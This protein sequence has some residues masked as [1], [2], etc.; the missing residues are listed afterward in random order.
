MWSPETQISYLDG[1]TNTVDNFQSWFF[2]WNF[3]KSKGDIQQFQGHITK[4]LN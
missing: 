1:E 2:G 4:V 3:N